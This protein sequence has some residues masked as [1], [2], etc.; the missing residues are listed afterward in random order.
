LNTPL[1][2]VITVVFNAVQT[3]ERTILSVINQTYPNIEY[4]VIDG[5]STDGTAEIIK[6]YANRISYWVSEKDNGIYFAMNKGIKAAKGDLINF[7]NAGDIFFD[8]EALL[9]M[10]T[11]WQKNAH[12][13]ILYGHAWMEFSTGHRTRVK[14]GDTVNSLWKGPIFR[15]NAMLVNAN[16]QKKYLFKTDKKYNIAADF[17]FIYHMHT[18]GKQFV[19]Y[20]RDTMVFT[21]GGVSSGAI[22]CIKDNRMIVLSYTPK[23]IY[24]LWHHLYLLKAR[25]G[26][27]YRKI[28]KLLLHAR[29][30][31]FNQ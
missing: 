18:L 15:H 14:A 23:T 5:G 10:V 19:L 22:R 27:V 12:P 9:D 16:L 24:S 28:E 30:K 11:A 3:V 31:N 1:V 26:M 13:D 2:S 25:V 6:R 7:M 8:N 17:D 29:R 4:V 21:D 20:N